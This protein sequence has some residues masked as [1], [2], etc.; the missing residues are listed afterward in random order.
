VCMD[1]IRIGLFY[2][3]MDVVKE[4]LERAKKMIEEVST[5]PT[6]SRGSTV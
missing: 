4:N 1:K 3:D 6:A 2:K 5:H